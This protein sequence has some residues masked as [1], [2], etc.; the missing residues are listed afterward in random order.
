MLTSH[1]MSGIMYSRGKANKKKE[2]GRN[3]KTLYRV[4]RVVLGSDT[5][6]YKFFET[7]KEA[8][9]FAK[10]D[11]TGDVESVKVDDEDVMSCLMS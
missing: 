9:E 10:K 3:M 6:E 5:P 11:Y 7:R 1:S 4:S 2:W 8:N